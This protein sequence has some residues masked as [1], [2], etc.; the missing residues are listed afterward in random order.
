MQLVDLRELFEIELM[1]YSKL[2]EELVMQ[3]EFAKIELEENEM[4]IREKDEVLS[5]RLF[6]L[7]QNVRLAIKYADAASHLLEVTVVERV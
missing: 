5:V 2:R 7:L 1:G 6:V 4:T 3:F